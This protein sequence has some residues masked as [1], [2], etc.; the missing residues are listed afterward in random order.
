[1]A[2][3]VFVRF[4]P[5]ADQ[6]EA[7]E[8]ILRG[9][10]GNTRSEPG[11]RR[12]DFYRSTLAPSGTMFCLIERYVNDAAIQ[13]HRETRHYKDYRARIMDLLERPIDVTVLEP[14]DERSA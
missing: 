10:I 13:A 6:E 14:L 3:L 4:Y 5:K 9:M 7:V 8:S 2:A 11:C 1:M 12:Y